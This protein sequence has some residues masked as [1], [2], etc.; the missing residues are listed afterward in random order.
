M[1]RIMKL[2]EE[3]KEKIF[4]ELGIGSFVRIQKAWTKKENRWKLDLIRN[5]TLVFR[6]TH[7]IWKALESWEGEVFSFINE[8]TGAWGLLD[9]R[10]DGDWL[11]GR[12]TSWLEGWNFQPHPLP[13]LP[14][15][16]RDGGTGAEFSISSQWFDQSCLGLHRNPT[17]LGSETFQ[18]GE[19]LEMLW[20]WWSGG[21]MDTP[22]PSPHL[23]LCVSSTRLFPS[24][25]LL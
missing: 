16:E 17:R 19:H 7:S 21:G 11:P 8:R 13:T 6:K 3:T 10:L 20:G 22:H 18:A 5:K 14:D 2:L 24:C 25:T 4:Q 23:A 12:P 1:A 15:R 9:G